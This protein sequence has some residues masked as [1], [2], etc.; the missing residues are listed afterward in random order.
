MDEENLKYYLESLRLQSDKMNKASM[1]A[2]VG[3]IPEKLC[4]FYIKALEAMY[5]L[6]K[7]TE[8]KNNCSV[9]FV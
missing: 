1:N 9:C 8:G 6:H 7:W 5:V 3:N 4:L 2:W